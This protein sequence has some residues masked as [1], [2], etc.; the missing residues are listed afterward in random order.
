MQP[1]GTSRRLSLTA[2]T[3]MRR[4]GQTSEAA[5][6]AFIRSVIQDLLAFADAREMPAVRQNAEAASEALTQELGRVRAV[7]LDVM[8]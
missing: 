1:L 3:D 7:H 6:L 2:G 5:D 4:S 8:Q